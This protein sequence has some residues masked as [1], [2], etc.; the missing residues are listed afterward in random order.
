MCNYTTQE[1]ETIQLGS[2]MASTPR[3]E[4]R[5]QKDTFQYI[6]LR[7]GLHYSRIKIFVMKYVIT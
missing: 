2:F 3:G 6:P 4:V 1:P 5:E 7:R